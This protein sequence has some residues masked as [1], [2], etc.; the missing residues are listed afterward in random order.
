MTVQKDPEGNERKH[1]HKYVGF[2]GKRVLEVGCGDGRLTWKYAQTAQSV[3]ALDLDAQ[4]LRVAYI[5]C[6]SDLRN[7]T[8]FLRA[9]SLNLPFHK[10]KFDIALLAWSL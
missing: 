8:S 9:D 1:L 5:D 4:D 3:T 2:T 6:P 7:T 10:E